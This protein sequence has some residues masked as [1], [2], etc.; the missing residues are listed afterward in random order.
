[1]QTKETGPLE[2]GLS[3][4]TTLFRSTS[5]TGPP[6]AA[7]AAETLSSSLRRVSVQTTPR[8]R[9]SLRL[10]PEP[11]TTS[12][13]THTRTSIPSSCQ[14]SLPAGARRFV[15]WGALRLLHTKVFVAASAFFPAES[16]RSFLIS[17]S[18]CAFQSKSTS[19]CLLPDL[20][21][22][23]FWPGTTKPPAAL[24]RP[25]RALLSSHAR[26]RHLNHPVS[27][28]LSAAADTAA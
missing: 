14:R 19:A 11:A 10:R 24:H 13:P 6:A 7:A 2:F 20:C 23:W 17:G 16:G 22:S 8:I 15:L 12:S 9:R 4:Q 5:E 27:L 26:I 28:A 25:P 18:S 1:M 3:K 21:A